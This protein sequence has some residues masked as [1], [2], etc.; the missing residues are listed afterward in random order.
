MARFLILRLRPV[1]ATT[2]L[3]CYLQENFSGFVVLVRQGNRTLQT[4]FDRIA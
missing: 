4:R 2:A 3:L 1:A